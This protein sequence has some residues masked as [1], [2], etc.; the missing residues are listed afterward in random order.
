VGEAFICRRFYYDPSAAATHDIGNCWNRG[1]SSIGSGQARFGGEG[2]VAVV[3]FISFQPSIFG[4]V[5]A[6]SEGTKKTDTVSP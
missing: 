2:V 4:V 1:I 6:A 3:Y 5:P